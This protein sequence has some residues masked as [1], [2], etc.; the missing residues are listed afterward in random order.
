MDAFAVSISSGITLKKA[1]IEDAL[2]VATFFGGFQF[3]MP[4][5]GWVAGLGLRGFIASVDHWIAFALLGWIGWQMIVESREVGCEA[6]GENPRNLYVLLG[7]AIATSID[8][9]AVGLSFS[10]LNSAIAGLVVAIGIVTFV[11]SFS[12]VFIGNKFGCVF[13]SQ[14]E[15]IGGIILIGIGFKILIQDLMLL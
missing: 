14:V 8:A 4:L 9:L 5:I 1:R 15:L 10:L 2:L 7:L 12:G 11:L 3:L 6:K 13:E